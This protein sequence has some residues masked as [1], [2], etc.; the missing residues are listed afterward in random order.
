MKTCPVCALDLEDSYLFC[1][2]DGSS[3]GVIDG[4]ELAAAT[5]SRDNE[6]DRSQQVAAGIDDSECLSVT[7]PV[8]GDRESDRRGVFTDVQE[9]RLERPGFRVAA[10]A[11]V[12]LLAVLGFVALYSFVSHLSRRTSPSAARVASQTQVAQSLPFVP[13]PREAQDYKEAQSAPEASSTPEP[14]TAPPVEPRHNDPVPSSAVRNIRNDTIA[15]VSAKPVATPAPTPVKVSS[16]ALPPLPRSNSGGFDARLIRVRS[17][18]T[19]S[20]FRYDLTF[21][22]QE[23][24]GRS[25]LWQRLLISSRSASGISHSQAVPFVHRLGA[26][27]AL[28]FTISV[29]MTGR[30]ESDWQGRVVCTTLGWDNNDRPLQASFGANITP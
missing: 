23:Q 15:H 16:P 24:A 12:I 4:N 27:G 7:A 13:T 9:H 28:T 14:R 2:D 11:T 17:M 22:M 5:L 6:T 20:G 10:I 8:E 3:L 25:A 21:N 30:S 26:T 1:P 29:E 19:S 18:K